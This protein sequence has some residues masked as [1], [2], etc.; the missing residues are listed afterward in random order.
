MTKRKVKI[1]PW[2]TAEFLRTAEDVEDYLSYVFEEGDPK[3]INIAIGNVLR[4]KGM[5]D[6]ARKMRVTRTHLYKSFS[7]IGNP[8]FQSAITALNLVG[9]TLQPKAKTSSHTFV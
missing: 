7:K 2:D 1:A 4:S 6:I 8:S 3:M 5:T 9:I